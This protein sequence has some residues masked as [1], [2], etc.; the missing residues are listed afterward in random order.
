[1]E[2]PRKLVLQSEVDVRMHRKIAKR[3]GSI[4]WCCHVFLS[5]QW[6]SI[7]LTC[8]SL[9]VLHLIVHTCVGPAPVCQFPLSSFDFGLAHSVKAEDVKAWKVF[10]VGSRSQFFMGKR[11]HF[12]PKQKTAAN[13]T[14]KLRKIWTKNKI[15]MAWQKKQTAIATNKSLNLDERR[16]QKQNRTLT[17]NHKTKFQN[18]TDKICEALQEEMSKQYQTH[19]TAH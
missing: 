8:V 18:K 10:E 4:P 3:I 9:S 5:F 14:K 1:M 2:R 13:K 11:V 16:D 15:G 19:P 12:K 6:C 17:I 7:C